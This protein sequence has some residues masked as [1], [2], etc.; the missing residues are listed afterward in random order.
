MDAGIADTLNRLDA[1][2]IAAWLDDSG[3]GG[4]WWNSAIADHVFDADTAQEKAWLVGSL[5]ARVP[6]LDSDDW[7]PA[8]EDWDNLFSHFR[9]EIQ[10]RRDADSSS[11]H[12]AETPARSMV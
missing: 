11:A 3:R 7:G 10:A 9:A 8:D 4:Q 1:Q 5:S 12:A 6:G 2:R